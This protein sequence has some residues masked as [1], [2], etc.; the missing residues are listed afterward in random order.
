V[1]I[2]ELHAENQFSIALLC[3]IAEVSRASYYK[4]LNRTPSSHEKLNEEILLEIKRLYK[5]VDGI[6][7]YRRMT[8]T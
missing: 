2:K 5:E 4:W 6:F 7:G 1:A 3:D 8:E